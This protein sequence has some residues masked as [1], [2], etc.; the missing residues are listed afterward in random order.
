MMESEVEGL[1]MRDRARDR[2][3]REVEAVVDWLRICSNL[4]RN[5]C[6]IYGVEWHYIGEGLGSRCSV[7]EVVGEVG[8]SG[9]GRVWCLPPRV[10]LCP[11]GSYKKILEVASIS[12][13][14]CLRGEMHRKSEAHDKATECHW[15]ISKPALLYSGTSKLQYLLAV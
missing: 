10:E 11:W 15:K 3:C 2:A 12:L 13:K 6:S 5:C 8:A 4:A 14:Q 7:V 9:D 1:R